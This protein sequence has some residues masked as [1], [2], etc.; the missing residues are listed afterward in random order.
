MLE[1]NAVSKRFGGLPALQ[2][3]SFGV[4]Q[5]RV[6]ALIGPNGAGKSTLI[7][8]I[9]GVDRADGGRIR[10]DAKA[11]EGL[12][13]HAVAA[14]GI[15][16][17]FQNLKLFARLSVLDNVLTGLTVRAERSFTVSMLRLPRLRHQERRL[18]L[19][20]LEALD[21]VGLADKANWPAGALAYGEKKRVEL[22]RAFVGSPRLV[23][24]DEPVAG[25]NSDET[26]H[27]ARHI[28]RQRSVGHTMLLV[29]HDME[30]VMEVADQVVVLD[31]GR[32][33]AKGPPGTIRRNPLVLEAYLGRMEATA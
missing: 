7:N 10:L 6:T 21:D 11:I 23:L 14:L 27:I 16:R 2:A 33:I 32:C 1:L 17:T 18:R 24:L 5:G 28:R 4:G 25:L 19:R 22:A 15:A 8:C 20:A 30:L 3:V 12:P 31:S 13:A 29:E 9:S 26:A